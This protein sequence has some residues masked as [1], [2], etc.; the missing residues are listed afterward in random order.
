M[1]PEPIQDARGMFARIFCEEELKKIGHKKN[2]VQIN[3]SL[4]V[5]KGSLRGMHY[6]RKPKAEIKFV[7]C[8]RGSVFDVIVDIRKA[9]PTFMQ[10]HGELLSEKNMR[11]I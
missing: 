7:K 5:K 1:E 2:I 3:H 9:S 6:Q 10:W 8:I 4:N 11:M